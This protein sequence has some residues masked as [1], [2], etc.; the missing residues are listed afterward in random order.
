MPGHIDKHTHTLRKLQ[1]YGHRIHPHRGTHYR[2]GAA[3]E[4]SD[5]HLWTGRQS[6]NCIAS[7]HMQPVMIPRPQS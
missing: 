6:A 3:T 7:S 5:K 4:S 2:Y 1:M